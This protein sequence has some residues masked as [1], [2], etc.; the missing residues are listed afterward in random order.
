MFL[1]DGAAETGLLGEPFELSRRAALL[2][3]WLGISRF[4][5]LDRGLTE[6]MA[7]GMGVWSWLRRANTR[8]TQKSAGISSEAKLCVRYGLFK[9]IENLADAAQ[10]CM[11]YL[12]KVTFRTFGNRIVSKEDRR[13][14]PSFAFVY[15]IQVCGSASK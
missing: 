5:A 12:G 10:L 14:L 11:E 4:A 6:M 9:T 8:E 3:G 13:V 7:W 15:F 1:R 2:M